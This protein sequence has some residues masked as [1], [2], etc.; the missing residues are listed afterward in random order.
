VAAVL[1]I[2]GEHHRSG[3]RR[4]L[5]NE[6]DDSELC[7]IM[8]LKLGAS[9]FLLGYTVPLALTHNIRGP[10]FFRYGTVPNTAHYLITTNSKK[11]DCK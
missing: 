5:F 10:N 4:F 1:R 3:E 7:D 8:H 11:L 6:D 9:Q 2:K